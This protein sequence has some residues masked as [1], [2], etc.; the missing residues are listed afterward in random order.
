MC[1]VKVGLVWRSSVAMAGHWEPCPGKTKT[2]LG[3][4]GVVAV[5]VLG[6][7]LLVASAWSEVRR[8]LRLVVWMVA[9]CWKWVRWVRVWAVWVRLVVGCCS[10]WVASWA[11]WAR[12]AGSVLADSNHGNNPPSESSWS[13]S[14]ASSGSVCGGC[15]RITCAFVPLTPKDDTAARR[16]RPLS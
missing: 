1:W 3:L 14:G 4:G 15:S 8:S 7:G 2:V 5:W 16:E 13:D 9:R 12:R 10:R 6:V 11:A